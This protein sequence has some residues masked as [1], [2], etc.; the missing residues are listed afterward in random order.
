VPAAASQWTSFS[1]CARLSTPNTG[2]PLTSS[3]NSGL[4]SA[5]K[6]ARTCWMATAW[7]SRSAPGARTVATSKARP[8][9]REAQT[10]SSL[11]GE[12]LGISPSAMRTVSPVGSRSSSGLTAPPAGV[13]SSDKVSLMPSRRPSAV[14]RWAVTAGL[15][16]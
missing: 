14:K 11:R 6:L 2:A 1:I 12:L 5:A 15:S 10:P 16:W 8:P 3:F 4:F 9:W 7:A 13:P